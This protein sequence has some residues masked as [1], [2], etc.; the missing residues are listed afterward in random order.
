VDREKPMRR[1]WGRANSSNVMKVIW[2]LEELGLPYERVDV[3]G[4]YGKTDTPEYRAMNPTRLV[5]TLQE[6]EFVLWESNAIVRYLADANTGDTP[7]WPREPRARASI[8]RWM[9]CQQTQLTG[10]QSV[11]FWGLVRTPP[12]KRD[13]A[14]IARAT[15]GAARAWGLLESSL[16]RF[17]YI[18]GNAFTLADIVWGPHVHRWFVMPVERPDMPYLRAWY[19]RLLQRPAY[20]AHCAGPLS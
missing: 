15:E 8:D 19:E 14:A 3:G 20:V 4:A 18:A 2:L 11:V 13:L 1:V 5:P 6:D 10:P 9:D 17:P 16:T 12:E 7:L